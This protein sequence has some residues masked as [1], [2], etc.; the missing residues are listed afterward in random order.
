MSRVDRNQYAEAV[1]TLS[2]NE[3]QDVF[4]AAEPPICLLGGWAVH[5]HITDGFRDA[6]DRPYIGSRDID[7]GIHVDPSWSTSGPLNS[8]TSIRPSSNSQ[9]NGC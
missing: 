1:T 5:L 9:S 8:S 7:L 3:L 6:H 4:S 2:E